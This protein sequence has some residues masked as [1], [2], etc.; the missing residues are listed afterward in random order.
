MRAGPAAKAQ[1]PT[2]KPYKPKYPA[3]KLCQILHATE[4]V[5]HKK[6]EE[7]SSTIVAWLQIHPSF[8]DDKDKNLQS[9]LTIL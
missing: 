3:Y 9:V 6:L 2:V 5:Y 8:R 4:G 7:Q 1:N